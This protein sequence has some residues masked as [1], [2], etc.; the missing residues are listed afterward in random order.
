MIES[1]LFPGALKRSFPRIKC[2]GSHLPDFFLPQ[3]P[4]EFAHYSPEADFY[5]KVEDVRRMQVQVVVPDHD[6]P[7]GSWIATCDPRSN[8]WLTGRYHVAVVLQSDPWCALEQT[9]GTK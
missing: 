4:D 3:R 2:G 8:A 7:S 5:A 6:L 9:R 1:R